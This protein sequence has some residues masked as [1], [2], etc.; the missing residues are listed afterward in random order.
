MM[1][2]ADEKGARQG[3]EQRKLLIRDSGLKSEKKTKC[4]NSELQ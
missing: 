1:N 4:F 2:N 3:G